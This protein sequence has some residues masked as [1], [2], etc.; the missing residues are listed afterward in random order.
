MVTEGTDETVGTSIVDYYYR[1]TVPHTVPHTS[2][3]FRL[4][5][6]AFMHTLHSILDVAMVKQ[7]GSQKKTADG[8]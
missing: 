5:S 4:L 3:I 7:A 8:I 1:Y 2:V 6:K